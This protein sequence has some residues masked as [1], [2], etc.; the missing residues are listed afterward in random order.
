MVYDASEYSRTGTGSATSVA[1]N[2]KTWDNTIDWEFTADIKVT[3]N[4]CRI[5][6]VPPSQSLKNHLGIGKNSSN[7]LTAYV[8]NNNGD[9]IQQ[10][11]TITMTNNTYYHVKITKIGTTVKFYFE[12]NLILTDSSIASQWLRNYNTESVKFT[13]WQSNKIYMKNMIVKPL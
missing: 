2:G 7:T 13:T 1:A 12:D 8:G 10:T 6:I 9:A 5:D 3:G 4:A 11:S